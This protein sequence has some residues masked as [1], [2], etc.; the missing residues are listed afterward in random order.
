MIQFI[1]GLVLFILTI[2]F[3]AVAIECIIGK[4]S[5]AGSASLV[6]GTLLLIRFIIDYVI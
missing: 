1:V 4:D 5:L 2:F 6:V 3:I